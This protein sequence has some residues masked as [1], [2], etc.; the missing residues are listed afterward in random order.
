[1][2]PASSEPW[3]GVR[4]APTILIAEDEDPIRE[5]LRTAL[6]LEGYQ[7]LAA[8]DGAVALTLCERHLPDLILLDLMMPRL[9]GL[10][11]LHEFRRHYP[12]QDVPV[13]IMSAVRTATEHAKAAGVAGVFP[14]PFDLDDL[15]ATVARTLRRGGHGLGGTGHSRA[16][17]A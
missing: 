4:A 14:K 17:S 6:E 8:G 9:D 7:V 15:L 11:F 12:G 3:L 13:Y 1:M 2:K 10:G 16:M 5:F